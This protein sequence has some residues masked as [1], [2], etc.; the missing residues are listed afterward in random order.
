MTLIQTGVHT[1][2]WA[3]KFKNI[4]LDINQQDSLIRF[5][6]KKKKQKNPKCSYWYLLNRTDIWI[7]G[8]WYTY[9]MISVTDWMLSRKSSK[10]LCN[11]IKGWTLR[12]Y[13]PQLINTSDN[14]HNHC[15]EKH[16]P[17]W[18]ILHIYNVPETKKNVSNELE[19][20]YTRMSNL[21]TKCKFT[22]C[23]AQE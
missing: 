6:I 1:F 19:E 17:K 3:T 7:S 13:P 10:R 12:V 9:V 15:G 8:T 14:S 4:T 23:Q 2:C 11:H 21:I 22:F 18:I 16:N 5:N 20:N